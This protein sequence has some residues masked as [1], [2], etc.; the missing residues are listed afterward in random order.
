[1]ANEKNLRIPT[2]EEARE[3]G[4]KGGKRSGEVRRAKRTMKHLAETFLSLPVSDKKRRNQ[5]KS[6][7]L[8]PDE[9]DNKMAIIV[10][11]SLSAADGDVRAAREIRSII[12][13]D[14]EVNDEVL[15]KLDDVLGEINSAF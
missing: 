12:G 10:A 11:L 7:G 4:R 6:L 9:I 8:D 14:N 2:S 5:L 13:E 15:K 1:M 3:M